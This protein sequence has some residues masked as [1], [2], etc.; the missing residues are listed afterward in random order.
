MQVK[1]PVTKAG[2]QAIEE[3][4]FNGVSV[5]AT[6]CFTVPQALAVAEA[7]E[8]GLN[9]RTLPR[10]IHREMSPVCTI[11][12]GRTD[13]WMKAVAKRDGIDIDPTYLDWAGIA[14]MK[15]PTGSSRKKATARACWRRPT[16]TWGTGPSS[17]A[18]ISCSPSPT[19][20]S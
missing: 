12:V 6:V 3:A 8:R 11:M 10:Q 13:D 20:G 17:S 16:A 2:I 18:A 9:R 19:N 5:N 1:A 14:C 7:V 15:R 4:T